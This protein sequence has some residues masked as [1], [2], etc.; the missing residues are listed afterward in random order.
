MDRHD[1]LR[2]LG[3][4]FNM[5]MGEGAV[6]LTTCHDD[7]RLVDDL[8]L[9]S[10]GMLYLVIAIEEFFNVRFDEVGAFDLKTVGQVVDYIEE[11]VS[12]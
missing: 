6:D 3:E 2:K 12:E 8:G 7:T 10:V 9:N 4:I 1:I 5:V 11:K